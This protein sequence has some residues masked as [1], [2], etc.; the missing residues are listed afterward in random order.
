MMQLLQLVVQNKPLLVQ[1]A[2][3][4]WIASE[5]RGP[6][7]CHQVIELLHLISQDLGF[8]T[9]LLLQGS[10]V[11]LQRFGGLRRIGEPLLERLQLHHGTSQVPH[12]VDDGVRL[13]PELVD[14]EHG[15]RHSLV[16]GVEVGGGHGE[17]HHRSSGLSDSRRGDVLQSV[18]QG[19]EVVPAGEEGGVRWESRT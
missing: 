14:H 17:G 18:L 4:R 16:E 12:V 9:V 10:P 19:L 11:L 7:C 3:D 6:T 13:P 8:Q 2:Q 5:R 1:E 15:V